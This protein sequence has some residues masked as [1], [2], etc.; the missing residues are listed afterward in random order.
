MNCQNLREQQN[1]YHPQDCTGDVHHGFSG[2]G[3]RFVGFESAHIGPREKQKQ[4][5]AQ[6]LLTEALLNTLVCAFLSGRPH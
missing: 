6:V 4:L 3:A 5:V 2:G 1:V